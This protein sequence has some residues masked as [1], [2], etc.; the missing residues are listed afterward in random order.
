MVPSAVLIL[1][2]LLPLHGFAP[3]PS[4]TVRCGG[5]AAPALA[6]SKGEPEVPRR[7]FLAR[8]ASVAAAAALV[9]VGASPRAAHAT[10]SA[11]TRREQDWAQRQAAGDVR[12]STAGAL[13]RQLRE[14]APMNAARSQ[15]FCPNGRPSS[16]S[17]LME[18]K[19][20]DREAMPSVFG[21]SEDVVGNSI[22]GFSAS[23]AAPQLGDGAVGIEAIGGFPNYARTAATKGGR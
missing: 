21:R 17:P 18:N 13:R 12:I 5:F 20:S 3:S 16:V 8:L 4:R 6:A 15:V 10:Y 23:Y 19:C 11:Y 2:M 22:P 1:L 14:I 9:D 7:E